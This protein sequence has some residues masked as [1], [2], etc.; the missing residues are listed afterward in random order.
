MSDLVADPGVEQTRAY[1]LY[2]FDCPCGNRSLIGDVDPDETEECD[3]CFEQ[4]P[5]DPSV[6]DGAQ[7]YEIWVFDCPA[8]TGQTEIGDRDPAGVEECDDCH[9]KVPIAP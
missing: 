2:V 3:S 7:P 1:T 8:C 4:I 6:D 9:A 5:M